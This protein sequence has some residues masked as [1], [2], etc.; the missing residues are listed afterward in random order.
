MENS[1]EHYK[2][3]KAGRNWVAAL[4]VVGTIGLVGMNNS[5]T[6]H[7]DTT[8]AV[9]TSN[10]S[11]S[12]ASQSKSASDHSV[13]TAKSAATT[14]KDN[15]Q[16]VKK[17]SSSATTTTS[18]AASS[19]VAKSNATSSSVHAASSVSSTSD[20]SGK[21]ATSNG[22][23]S[24]TSVN[25]VAA[26]KV[27]TE[28]SGAKLKMARAAKTA[29]STTGVT[30]YDAATPVADS[31]KA[32]VPTAGE[33]LADTYTFI[34]KYNGS[35]KTTVTALGTTIDNSAYGDNGVA[36][37][38]NQSTKGKTGFLYTNVGYDKSGNS[39]DMKI[40]Y[41]NWG[42]LSDAGTP[43]IINTN[44]KIE[45][46]LAGIGWVDCEY[47]FF[48]HDTNTADPVSGLLTL[49]DIDGQQTVSLN[50][51]TWDKIDQVL[52][53]TGADLLTNKTDNWL[54]EVTQ[55]G[56]HTYVAPAK[57]SSRNAEYA[58]LTFTYTNQSSL[59]FRFSN[60]RST[61]PGMGNWGVNYIAQ[62]PMAT[63][64]VAP[65]LKVSNDNTNFNTDNV[66]PAGK[67]SYTYQVNQLIPDEWAQFYYPNVVFEGTLPTG[68]TLQSFKV[69]NSD[70][71]D[72]TNQF[73]NQSSGTNLKLNVNA[74][75]LQSADFYGKT[76]QLL[77]TVGAPKATDDVQNLKFTV[78][79]TI[80]DVKKSSGTVTTQ[81][82]ANHYLTTH[83]YIEGTTQSL[84]PD[85]VQLVLPNT[86]FT[87]PDQ[88]ITGYTVDKT[89][90]QNVSGTF[91]DQN[92]SSIYY[93][94]ADPEQVTV[95]YYLQGT[96]QSLKPDT[97]S[98]GKYAQT[99]HVTAPEIT[100]YQLSKSSNASGTYSISNSDV[101]FEYAPLAEQVTVHYYL[102]GTTQSLKPDMTLTGKYAQ[103]YQAMAPGIT[104]YQL[105]KSSNVS[106]TYDISNPDAVFEYEPLAE[107]VTVHYYL[108]GTTRKLKSDTVLTGKYA[109]AYQIT[110]PEIT[111][112]QLSKSSNAS[113]IYSISNPDVVFEYSPLTEQVQI[114]YSDLHTNKILQANKTLTGK[115][116]QDYDANKFVADITGYTL[117]ILPKNIIGTYGLKNSEV[118]FSYEPKI[119]VLNVEYLDQHEKTILPS[120]TLSGLFGDKYDISHYVETKKGYQLKK[121]PK[122][123]GIFGEG[124][125]PLAFRYQAQNSRIIIDD[126]DD[127]GNLISEKTITGFYNDPYTVLPSSFNPEVYMYEKTIPNTE[128]KFGL[129]PQR[130]TNYYN[131]TYM[132]YQD[133]H[134]GSSFTGIMFNGNNKVIGVN[135]MSYTGS[136]V[137]A[138]VD[139]NNK[140]LQ[141]GLLN[142]NTQRIINPQ[143][144]QA[145]S[146]AYIVDQL[147]TKVLVKY[148]LNGT[149]FIQ[150]TANRY[151]MIGDGAS[152]DSMGNLTTTTTTL[153]ALP[154]SK[155]ATSNDSKKTIV[156]DWPY[157]Y[158]T[159]LDMTDKFLTVT[160][161]AG[162]PLAQIDFKSIG[163]VKSLHLLSNDILQVK[164]IS[165][166]EY[167]LILKSKNKVL[168]HEY[169]DIENG[170]VKTD[171]NIYQV[172]ENSDR[173]LT[174]ITVI[175]IDNKNGFSELTE[176]LSFQ[177]TLTLKKT[178]NY[179]QMV[180]TSKNSKKIVSAFANQK[181]FLELENGEIIEIQNNLDKTSE[182]CI[183][184]LKQNGQKIMQFFDKDG[185]LIST[186]LK[187]YKSKNKKMQQG[188]SLTK[189]IKF[190]NGR[191]RSVPMK[192]RL[193]WNKNEHSLDESLINSIKNKRSG[194]RTLP[195]TDEVFNDDVSRYGLYLL[196]LIF[197]ILAFSNFNQ[198]EKGKKNE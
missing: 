164:Q 124:Q 91:G 21:T 38:V 168:A 182:I 160:D 180:L 159:T 30:D 66:L 102:Q 142:E 28:T 131:R 175:N 147:G 191:T 119:M 195:Q 198:I 27:T 111:G 77:L 143:T 19:V 61:T 9:T 114:V 179:I 156:Q 65:T 96:T 158:E 154:G 13:S 6:V 79:T 135:Q 60:G 11:S 48:A 173:Q 166:N 121:S 137:Q 25:S 50:K 16:A 45:N 63:E 176:R 32:H 148:E 167:N 138:L 12:A 4:V 141:V 7:A 98:E 3:Y 181:K 86:S 146:S 46:L 97:T 41:T 184:I 90:S 55:D 103:D 117:K 8:N 128:L 47:E 106:G 59:K 67:T 169:V 29:D 163:R 170:M 42:R 112:Y 172:P 192:F 81:V 51:T 2:L 171:N 92:E 89:A 75:E 197:I 133:D 108:Q 144:I 185:N 153:T 129:V 87:A 14:N 150:H 157:D 73:T 183:S 88:A 94:Q 58:M 101:V 188:T 53:P 39:V 100:G 54:R 105:N 62:K 93:Y 52:I 126:R 115:Y 149:V 18:V 132:I 20:S 194:V 174:K 49:T 95:H 70:G 196:D 162:S 24:D 37:D 193:S 145:G 136:T 178:D 26:S 83:Y 72:V 40:V 189:K 82:P 186:D 34:P 130:V 109:Q 23:S 5:M 35:G 177:A 68:E 120:K 104:G 161:P 85:K 1:K 116:G 118:I 187:S 165:V 78:A 57:S 140:T 80:D 22:V 31:D 110:T 155:R 151:S 84:A 139:L 56:Y 15:S 107:Q 74:N 17:V 36:I 64:T 71:E 113:G 10:V 134:N 69:T 44:G 99:Y 33:K 123:I 152:V 190:Q 43:A 122:L 76:Y 127:F 125:S